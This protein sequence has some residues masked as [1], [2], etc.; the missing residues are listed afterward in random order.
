[1][2]DRELRTLLHDRSIVFVG[3]MGSGK[4]AVGR[5]VAAR[6]GLGFVDADDAIVEAADRMSIPEIFEKF[7]EAHF[8]RAEAGVIARLLKSGPQVLATGGGAFMN[9]ETRAIVH[10]TSVSVWLKADV[11]LLL[12]RIL[13][14]GIATR[15]MLKNGNPA[16]ILQHLI[17]VRSQTYAEA[18]LCILSRA[19]PHGEMVAEVMTRLEEFFR[20]AEMRRTIAEPRASNGIVHCS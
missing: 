13:R 15:P 5:R 16:S 3:M 17:D 8:R 18:D 10:A 4:T 6:L 2:S 12:E 9:H 7:G 1:M 20:S 11:S 14:K 19:V